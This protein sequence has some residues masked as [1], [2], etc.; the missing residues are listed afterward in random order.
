MAL[1]INFRCLIL[2]RTKNKKQKLHITYENYKPILLTFQRIERSYFVCFSTMVCTQYMHYVSMAEY[3]NN[4]PLKIRE[5]WVL[6][7][8]PS[9]TRYLIQ[10]TQYQNELGQVIFT[11]WKVGMIVSVLS[12]SQGYLN[13][14]EKINVKILCT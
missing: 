6:V 9:P 4:Y 2:D 13:I 3:F 1:S 8:V 10:R 11:N 14:N 7:L 12:K 5:L